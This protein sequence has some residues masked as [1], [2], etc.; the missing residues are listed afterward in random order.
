MSHFVRSLFPSITCKM[1]FFQIFTQVSSFISLSRSLITC[2]R[3]NFY[4]MWIIKHPAHHKI[5]IIG[6]DCFPCTDLYGL[7]YRSVIRIENALLH[8]HYLGPCLLWYNIFRI[9]IF[10]DDFCSLAGAT[11]TTTA[12][13]L[14]GQW[15]EFS[16]FKTA[17]MLWLISSAVADILITMCL[18]LSLVF[19]YLPFNITLVLTVAS[20]S[21]RLVMSK[22]T[23]TSPVSSGVSVFL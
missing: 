11:W 6:S 21:R 2:H 12:T 22:Q 19:I 7:A 9:R 15:D 17:P 13:A 5:T 3:R 23:S 16:N 18:C 1:S 8:R 10:P 20:G 14:Y 4:C